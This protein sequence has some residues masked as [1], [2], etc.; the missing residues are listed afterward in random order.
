MPTDHGKQTIAAAEVPPDSKG[1]NRT[2]IAVAGILP[3]AWRSV[4]SRAAFS[5][6][7]RKSLQTFSRA[8]TVS[9][10]EKTTRFATLLVDRRDGSRRQFQVIG[11]KYQHA[12][13]LLVVKLDPPEE[14]LL[15]LPRKLIEKDH[16]I[17]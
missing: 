1:T 9:R 14:G 13:V 11:Q 8:G 17:P 7:W 2:S 10:P 5:K 6:H 16:F 12:I 4:P 3:P 15:A